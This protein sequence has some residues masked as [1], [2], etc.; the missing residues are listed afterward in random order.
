MTLR[1]D[2][3]SA[4]DKVFVLKKLTAAASVELVWF[5]KGNTD[6]AMTRKELECLNP[7]VWLGDKVIITSILSLN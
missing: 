5:S 6:I 7:R 3:L 1:L 2:D 4:E